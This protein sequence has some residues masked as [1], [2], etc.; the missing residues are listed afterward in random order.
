[1]N[2]DT[3][4]IKR[5]AGVVI[6]IAL[7][8]VATYWYSASVHKPPIATVSQTGKGVPV[9]SSF[10]I[11]LATLTAAAPHVAVSFGWLD[12]PQ[13][14]SAFNL[15]FDPRVDG[16]GRE[17]A[18]VGDKLLLPV[19]FGRDSLV[20]ERITITYRNGEV[21]TV[22][23]QGKSRSSSTFQVVRSEPEDLVAGAETEAEVAAS[24]AAT[25]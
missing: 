11:P 18:L 8:G 13:E 22:R 6:A 20:P 14:G 2:I 9:S 25:E 10:G 4:R 16:R 19:T 12:A 23:Y 24:E 5:T 7:V 21:A 15:T 17:V 3:P 1:M